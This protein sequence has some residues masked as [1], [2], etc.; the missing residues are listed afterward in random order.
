[1]KMKYLALVAASLF[2]FALPSAT[3]AAEAYSNTNLNLRAG[4]GGS[5]PIVGRINRG[6]SL[7]LLGC[8]DELSWCEVEAWGNE[9]GWVSANFIGASYRDRQIGIRETYDLGI[10]K[11]ITF[12]LDDYWDDHYRDRDFYKNRRNYEPERRHA[13]PQ[14]QVRYNFAPQQQPMRQP[15]NK[16]NYQRGR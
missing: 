7:E 2:A 14:R 15:L 1:M 11:L 8:I 10:I 13:E 6:E 4:P 16:D 5:Y 3:Q 9:R 12:S